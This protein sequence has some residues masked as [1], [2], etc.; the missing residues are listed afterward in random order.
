MNILICS[1]FFYPS[2]GGAQKVAEELANNFIKKG[3]SVTVATSYIKNRKYKI[4]KKIKIREFKIGGNSVNG[5]KGDIQEYK[6]FILKSS[7]DL[8]IVYAAQQWTFD[9]ICNFIDEIKTKVL[10]CPCGFS[11]LNN[12]SYRKYFEK[13][14]NKLKKFNKNIFHGKTYQDFRFAKKNKIKNLEIIYNAA[15][16]EEFKYN[17]NN[18]F[19]KKY[20]LK[21]SVILNVANYSFMKGQDLSIMV[22]LLLKTKNV[23]LV[24][25]GNNLFLNKSIYF[26]FLRGISKIINFFFSQK[27]KSFF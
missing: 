13:L 27:K 23:S 4:Y 8:I 12:P 17:S 11:A 10:S 24:F 25:I 7:F 26:Q 1:E 16:L 3:N 6:N 18:N 9:L 20:N 15:S 5:I 19:K 2:V 21:G 22:L 14:P